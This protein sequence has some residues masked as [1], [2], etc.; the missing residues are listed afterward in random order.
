MMPTAL[1]RLLFVSLTLAWSAHASAQTFPQGMDYML[2]WQSS[3]QSNS[4]PGRF[5]EATGDAPSSNVLVN[6]LGV[7][8]RIPLLSNETRLDIAGLAGQA[9]FKHLP[10]FDLDPRHLDAD[11]HWRASRLFSGKVG[12]HHRRKRYESDLLWP[13]SDTVSTRRWD[14]E[15]GMNISDE[16][17]LPL[18][19]LF[20]EH[21]RYGKLPTQQLFNRNEK[22]WELAARYQSLTGSSLSVGMVQSRSTLPLRH[23]LARTDLDDAYRDSEVYTQVYWQYSVKTSFLARVGRLQRK[24]D[25]FSQRDTKLLTLDTQAIWRYSPKT[26]LRLGLWQRPFNNDEDPNIIYSTLRG[27]GI[28]AKWDATPKLALSL[29]ASYEDQEDTRLDA[30]KVTSPRMQ[31]GTRLSWQASPNLNVILDGFHS[32]KSG[33]QPW[34]RY[35]QNIVRLG[36]VLYTD[37]GNSQI[38]ALLNPA[39]CR[40][41][42]VEADLCP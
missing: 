17:T 34:N 7:A 20:D 12:Y 37:S 39:E 42:Y 27:V 10:E 35:R 40:W 33:D 4:N 18:V 11:F 29:R 22:G 13:D 14:T 5:S 30:Q 16:L 9:R 15:L 41:T 21:T 8:A 1:R 36:I 6:S 32:R 28:N 2:Q 25:N 38:G 19:R 24:Y 23:T 31:L 3:I 26:E